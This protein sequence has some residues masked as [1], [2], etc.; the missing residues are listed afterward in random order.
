M[1]KRKSTPPAPSPR[2]AQLP[3]YAA[4]IAPGKIEVQAHLFYPAWLAE[5]GVADADIDQYWLECAFQCMKL[6]IQLAVAGTGL[7]PRSGGALAILVNDS[8]K[9]KSGVS[10]YAQRAH[11]EG[12]GVA[13]AMNGKEARRHF[14]RL[15]GVLPAAV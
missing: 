13:A 12:R 11:P 2:P 6:E 14:Q 10:K 5:L 4:A 7:A 15:R 9:G 3:D 1:A 8:T